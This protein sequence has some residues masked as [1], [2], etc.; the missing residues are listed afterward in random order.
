MHGMLT[1]Q[2][3]YRSTPKISKGRFNIGL[4]NRCFRNAGDM[5]IAILSI[6]HSLKISDCLS[7]I[8][9]I[10]VISQTQLLARGL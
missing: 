3:L 6:G 9:I 7:H 10:S 4:M 2:P 8:L 1:P 5:L